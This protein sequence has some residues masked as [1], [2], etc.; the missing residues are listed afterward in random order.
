LKHK[1]GLVGGLSHPARGRY[2]D[3]CGVLARICARGASF[4]DHP[5]LD[6]S[7]N[8]EIIALQGRVAPMASFTT[9]VASDGLMAAG[10]GFSRP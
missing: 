4:G 3:C 5:V 7:V 1:G 9:P 10:W 8:Y 2:F 6:G